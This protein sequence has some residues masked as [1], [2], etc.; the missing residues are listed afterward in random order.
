MTARSIGWALVGLGDI[1]IKRVGPAILAQ[2]DSRLQACV[3]RDPRRTAAVL[4]EFQ[5]Q[6]VYQ[7]LDEALA[8]PLVDV[9]YLAT[10]VHLHAAQ[11]IAALEAGRD[12]LVEKPMALNADEGRQMCAVA[13][14]TGRRLAVAYYRRYW[15]RHQFVQEL[16]ASGRLGQLVL[17]R[18]MWH[19]WY[20]PSDDDP[21]AWRLRP[22]EA[23]GGVLADIGSHRIDLMSWWFGL[24]RRVVAD[25][26]TLVQPYAVEDAVTTLWDYAD[27]PQVAASFHWCTEPRADEL[28]LVGTRGA[29]TLSPLDTGPVELAGMEG[30]P[31]ADSYPRP[32][33]G[34][35]P[36]IEAFARAVIDGR[37]P[38]FDGSSG[39]AATT[40]IDAVYRSAQSGGWVELEPPA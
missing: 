14:A 25:V 26:R 40:I 3:T 1:A 9:V 37:P 31:P 28:H 10:P 34:H 19:Q 15:P 33:N 27:G 22:D 7:R 30:G 6:R 16:V 8:D 12:V 29:L 5:P 36:L 32:E 11:A 18:L 24:P 17:A 21:K 39:L 20:H 23:G 4:A 38:R 2:A 35:A 13:A